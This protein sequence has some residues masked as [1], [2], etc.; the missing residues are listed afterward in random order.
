MSEEQ[1]G[2]EE[3]QVDPIVSLPDPNIVNA[4]ILAIRGQQAIGVPNVVSQTGRTDPANVEMLYDPVA[5]QVQA[6]ELLTD[7]DKFL[8]IRNPSLWVTSTAGPDP[9]LNAP[10]SREKFKAHLRLINFL[11]LKLDQTK[12][13]TDA[14]S[15]MRRQKIR[16]HLK[17][18]KDEIRQSRVWSKLNSQ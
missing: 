4:P 5:Q 18:M 12:F 3:V 1:T 13:D 17:D 9:S 11:E 15:M 8:D 10:R 6:D 2:E 7:Q 14:M 16:D